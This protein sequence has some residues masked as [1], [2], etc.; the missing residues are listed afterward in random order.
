M[1]T[2]AQ[3]RKI[4]AESNSTVDWPSQDKETTFQSL[5]LDSLDY[6]DIIVGM[7]EASGFEVPDSDVAK[8]QSIAAIEAYF[9][10]K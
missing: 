1:L 2:E 5:G 4:I 10:D 7:Q 8:L 9:A 3:I 6:Y